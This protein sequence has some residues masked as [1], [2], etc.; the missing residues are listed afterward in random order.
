MNALSD[1]LEPG[2]IRKP[3]I[4]DYIQHLQNKGLKEAEK[5]K[6]EKSKQSKIDKF[7]E[8]GKDVRRNRQQFNT[9]FKFHDHMHAVTQG[10]T[11]TLAHNKASNFVTDIDGEQ[12][13]DEGVVIADKRTG[14]I[15]GKYVPQK[16]VHQLRHNPRFR[17]S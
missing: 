6:T 15:I 2:Q 3:N 12:S 4:D 13:T 7:L 8:M 10:L 9:L 17:R 1:G 5:V 16:V 14:Q 11:S